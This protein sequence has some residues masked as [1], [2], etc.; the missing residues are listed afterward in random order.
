M[1]TRVIGETNNGEKIVERFERIHTRKI[2]R[3][4]ARH[5]MKKHGY[6]PVAKREYHKIPNVTGRGY[7]TTRE[8]GYFSL[9]WR[10]AA[11]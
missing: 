2:D 1:E 7:Q 10:E 9:N 5:N 8:Q 11:K 4:V 3:A 6:R